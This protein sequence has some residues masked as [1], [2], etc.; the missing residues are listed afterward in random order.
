MPPESAAFGGMKLLALLGVFTLLVCDAAA[1]LASGLAGGLAFAA[2]AVL[3]AVAQITGF[4]GLDM[5]H[6][7]SP[8]IQ[9]IYRI[10][11]AQPNI[12]VNHIFHT[13][14]TFHIIRTARKNAHSEHRHDALQ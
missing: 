8:S 1:G 3:C 14:P 6:V 10:S 11:L 9:Q 4:D 7:F 13:F 12:S 5:F 2:A